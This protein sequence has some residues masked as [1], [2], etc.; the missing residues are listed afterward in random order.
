[1]RDLSLGKRRLDQFG[2]LPVDVEKERPVDLKLLLPP[3]GPLGAQIE[4]ASGVV[5][6]D[7]FSPITLLLAQQFQSKEVA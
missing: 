1:M 4:S 6:P 5:H 7:S 3:P 2:R